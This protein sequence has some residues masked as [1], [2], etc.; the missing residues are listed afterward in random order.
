MQRCQV[1]ASPGG[2]VAFAVPVTFTRIW[3]S[4]LL[5]GSE[6]VLL[7]ADSRS[8]PAPELLPRL[9]LEPCQP[10]AVADFENCSFRLTDKSRVMYFYWKINISLM[11]TRCTIGFFLVL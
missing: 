6:R 11:K 4:Q 3:G 8:Q 10:L 1:T 7:A 5:S 9:P 2:S